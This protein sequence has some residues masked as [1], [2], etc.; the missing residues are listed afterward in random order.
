MNITKTLCYSVNDLI[1][2]NQK[3]QKTGKLPCFNP[4][5]YGK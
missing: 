2:I 1:K 3:S 4:S 5:D